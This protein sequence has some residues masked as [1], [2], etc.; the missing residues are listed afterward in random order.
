MQLI[1]CSEQDA[2]R[3]IDPAWKVYHQCCLDPKFT[4]PICRCLLRFGVFRH[5]I[6]FTVGGRMRHSN[7]RRHKVKSRCTSAPV[8]SMDRHATTRRERKGRKREERGGE[9]Q[10]TCHVYGQ[11]RQYKR[12][13]EREEKGSK[14]R[15]ER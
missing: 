14:Q 13:T 15:K 6:Q 3:C 12:G 5:D 2:F 7:A 11:T 9:Y 8:T 10:R 4:E 1:V